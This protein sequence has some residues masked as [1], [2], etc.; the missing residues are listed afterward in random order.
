MV[1]DVVPERRVDPIP[2][3]LE[4]A[5]G[6]QQRPR[7]DG[8]D[9][10]A[11]GDA[12]GAGV[13]GLDEQVAPHVLRPERGGHDEDDGHAGEPGGH[14][15]E[16]DG[17]VALVEVGPGAREGGEGGGAVGERE[18]VQAAD[19]LVHEGHVV[20]TRVDDDCGGG[21]AGQVAEVVRERL[22][23]GGVGPCL[24]F[25]V[26][27]ELHGEELDRHLFALEGG[28]AC[29]AHVGAPVIFQAVCDRALEERPGGRAPFQGCVAAPGADQIFLIVAPASILDALTHAR[30]AQNSAEQTRHL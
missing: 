29:R 27:G 9:P 20:D 21:R 8:Q 30:A 16:V 5:R 14:A 28:G 12:G 1:V 22:L 10:Q 11:G 24:H 3:E 18:L 13:E 26:A 23:R 17:E 6:P 19:R 25:H 2:V 7:V 4:R 15:G